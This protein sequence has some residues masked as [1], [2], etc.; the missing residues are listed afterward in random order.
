MCVFILFSKVVT[1]VIFCLFIDQVNYINS[2]MDLCDV[3]SFLCK[4]YPTTLAIEL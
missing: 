3:N 2:I 1:C 4:K